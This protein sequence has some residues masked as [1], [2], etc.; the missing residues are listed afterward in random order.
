MNET[1]EPVEVI[2][3]AEFLAEEMIER[4]WTAVDVAARM[5]GR[6]T[7]QRSIDLLTV[8]LLLAVQEDNLVISPT[9]YRQLEHAFGVS[10]G[11]FESLDKPWHQYPDRRRPFTAPEF[12][13]NG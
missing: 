8:Q 2:S 1:R 13:F 7:K 12:L 11:F 9:L 10:E 3:L 5:G 6:D 4:E